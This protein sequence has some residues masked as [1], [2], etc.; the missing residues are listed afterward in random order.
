METKKIKF[1][2]GNKE[3]KYLLSKFGKDFFHDMNMTLGWTHTR[4][5]L[6]LLGWSVKERKGTVCGIK[7][8]RAS[9]QKRK[10]CEV[11]MSERALI[12]VRP[13]FCR[14]FWERRQERLGPDCEFSAK[15]VSLSFGQWDLQRIL[16][17]WVTWSTSYPEEGT[18]SVTGSKIE[19]KEETS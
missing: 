16:I 9:S 14:C 5:Q 6:L 18:L 4:E 2:E 3:E 7:G 11:R 10:Q 17:R 13:E 12:G 1:L 8:E 15:R 19:C